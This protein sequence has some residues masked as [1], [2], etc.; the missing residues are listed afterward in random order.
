MLLLNVSNTTSKLNLKTS[1]AIQMFQQPVLSEQ[2]KQKISFV[3][4]AA[5]RLTSQNAVL[6][7]KELLISEVFA[8]IL[9]FWIL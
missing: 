5:K 2:L 4:R 3:K 8:T 9:K 1:G 7:K 6:M